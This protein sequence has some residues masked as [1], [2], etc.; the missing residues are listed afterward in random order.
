MRLGKVIVCSRTISLALSALNATGEKPRR[1]LMAVALSISSRCESAWSGGSLRWRE[2]ES[3]AEKVREPVSNEQAAHLNPLPPLTAHCCCFNCF[4][5]RLPRVADCCRCPQHLL[6]NAAGCKDQKPSTLPAH[7][8]TRQAHEDVQ[9][10][11]QQQT[12][13][14]LH[15]WFSR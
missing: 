10:V 6:L 2:R 3:V 8:P 4:Y 7:G 9:P 12:L 15:S 11:L 1:A 13:Q 14:P 5:L